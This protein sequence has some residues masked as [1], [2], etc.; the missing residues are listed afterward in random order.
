MK[1][2]R[3]LTFFG[4]VLVG[5]AI[6]LGLRWM[7]PTPAVVDQAQ[8]SLVISAAARLKDSMN[9]IKP[10]Y[11]SKPNVSLTYNLGASG[12]LLQQIQNGAPADIFISAGK[13][14]MDT[15]E[16]SGELVA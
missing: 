7:T 3:F 4:I 15:L 5:L 16:K 13:Q 8:A 6:A 9:E 2:S 10:L 1:R 11:Q 14:Q 12:A